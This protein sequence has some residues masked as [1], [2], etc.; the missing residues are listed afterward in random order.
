M[1]LPTF[2]TWSRSPAFPSAPIG[3]SRHHLIAPPSYRSKTAVP[4]ETEARSIRF[5]RP[6]LVTQIEPPGGD[7]LTVINVHLRARLRLPSLAKSSSPLSGRRSAAG[8]RGIFLSAMRRAD[9]TVELRFLLEELFDARRLR[10]DRGC[11][12]LQCRGPRSSDHP[13]RPAPK[14]IPEIRSWR[15]APWSFSTA[16]CPQIAAGA[17]SHHGR[18]QMLDHI[19]ASRALHGRFRS[20]EIHDEGLSDELVGYAR[21]ISASASAHARCGVGGKG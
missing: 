8:R 16:P 9:Q 5:D 7:L 6:I 15:S 2:T 3:R 11:R 14:R 18:R 12:R 4:A 1:A 13:G 21:H 20:I 10:V 19:L 17:V